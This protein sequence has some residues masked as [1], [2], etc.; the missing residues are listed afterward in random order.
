MAEC[1]DL[2]IRGGT[3]VPMER[4]GEYHDGDVLVRGRHIAAVTRGPA[5]D[6]QA[7][8][9]LDARDALV[10]PGL[11]QAHV[12]VVQSLLRHQ[13]D[14]LQLLDWLRTR[15]WPYEAALDPDGV[16]AAAELGIAELLAGGTTTALDFGSV[17]Y[18]DEVFATAQRMGIRMVSGKIHMGPDPAVPEVLGENAERSLVEAEDLGR[19]W[20]GA[21]DGRLR[22]AVTPRF[23]LS[24]DDVMM[25]GCAD[26]ARRH[27][28]LVHTHAAENRAET[29]E[30]R[31]RTG[32]GN[33][34]HLAHLGL[35]GEDVVIAHCIH[36]APGEVQLLASTGT[37]VC[38]CPGANLKL[39]SGIADV[40][41]LLA[42]GVTVALGA[43]GPP[44]NNRLSAFSEMSLASTLHT[45]SAGAD[46][47][48][49]WTALAMATR[50]GAKAVGLGDSVGVLAPGRLADVTVVSTRAWSLQPGGDP[51][52]RLVHGATV[53]DVRHVVVDGTPR[54]VDHVLADLDADALR[55]RA[56][57][58]W[59]AT[60]TRMEAAP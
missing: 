48:P 56:R 12:H 6:V 42:A 49:A 15:V 37:T 23:V 29:E 5:R 41:G 10:I 33:I 31:R 44:C 11:V 9:V 60:R 22:Y 30:V 17:R 18:Q 28:W 40:P 57:A 27:G 47:V 38:H 26:L 46:A 7:A 2:W 51:A 45:L 14:G 59:T 32:R 50:A 13:A 52:S 19:R 1:F 43:D 34:E 3:V 55:R 39:A 4:P 58:A 53:A 25:R 20:H 36:L 16:A 21:A 54:V 35:T 8:T 24:C